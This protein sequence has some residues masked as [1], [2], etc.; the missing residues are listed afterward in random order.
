MENNFIKEN[1]DGSMIINPFSN[2]H[3]IRD[4]MF[5]NSLPS[6]TVNNGNRFSAVFD[7]DEVLVN[8]SDKWAK[9]MLA[10]PEL[11]KFIPDSMV[12]T[13][14]LGIMNLRI[15]NFIDRLLGIEFGS[16]EYEIFMSLYKDDPTF[17]DDL[18]PSPFLNAVKRTINFYDE[19][20]I[21]TKMPT[22]DTSHTVDISK[23]RF[24]VQHLLPLK[25][26]NPNLKINII[27]LKS[28]E[29][30]SDAILE[31]NIKFNTFA[32]DS[33]EN[34]VDVVS[35]VTNRSYEVLVPMY[36]YNYKSLEEIHKI[37][38]R[39]AHSFG[40]MY[41]FDSPHMNPDLL[42]NIMFKLF[43]EN[44]AQPNIS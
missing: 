19:I 16:K 44:E 43:H 23:K 29:K 14:N 17:Y 41:N 28:N 40:F 24:L 38:N 10:V 2:K 34:I 25:K 11:R 8:I 7:C 4:S 22:D 12:Q 31:Q 42:K 3:T 6:S 33:T 9:K 18:P 32:D 30:K 37:E 5:V 21:I 39:T 36:G 26:E 20:H 1:N 27:F 35:N 13:I 15:V